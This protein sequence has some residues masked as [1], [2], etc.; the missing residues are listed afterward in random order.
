MV[1]IRRAKNDPGGDR[2]ANL[3]RHACTLDEGFERYSFPQGVSYL[4]AAHRVSDAGH[5]R[6]GFL[7][8]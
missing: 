1:V 4:P 7:L 2:S 8:S 3:F 6:P 5:R